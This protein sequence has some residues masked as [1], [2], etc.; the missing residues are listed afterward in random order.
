LKGMFQ[1]AWDHNKTLLP[2]K[3]ALHSNLKKTPASK[4]KSAA[5]RA[6]GSSAGSKPASKPAAPA[7][8]PPSASGKDGASLLLLPAVSSPRGTCRLSS[9]API[10]S[11]W[12]ISRLQGPGAS[13]CLCARALACALAPLYLGHMLEL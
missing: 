9:A 4:A 5:L 6:E 7:H 3:C 12:L 11:L 1:D 10:T 2:L 13:F 8:L